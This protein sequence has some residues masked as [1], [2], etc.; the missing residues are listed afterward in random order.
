VGFFHADAKV[1]AKAKPK[2]RLQDI[3]VESLQRLGCGACPRDADRSLSS[4]KMRSQGEDGAEVFL[5]LAAPTRQDDA[6]GRFLEDAVGREI[7][8]AFGRRYAES[9]L[10]VGGAVQCAG[11]ETPG[12]A[13]IEC[14][15]GRVVADIE[16]ARPLVVVTVGDPPLAWATGLGGAIPHRGTLMVARI[17]RHECYVFPILFP[18]YVL[19]KKQFGGKSEY[20]MALHHDVARLKGLVPWMAQNPP[21]VARAPYDGGVEVVTGQEPGDMQRLE[22]ALGAIAAAPANAMDIETNCLRPFTHRRP[23]ILTAACGTFER[24]VAFALDHPDGWGSDH[25]R[26]RA[27]GLFYDFL[28]ES[29]RTACH[30]LAFEM[31]WIAADGGAHA[32][33]RS[34]WDDTMASAYTLDERGGTKSLGVQTQIHFG[35]DLKAQSRVDAARLLDYPIREVLRYNGMDAKWTNAVR[36]AHAPLLDAVPGFREL[37]EDKVALAP[38]L[39][40]TTAKG[41]P[42]DQAF[43]DAAVRRL[44]GE[45]AEIEARLRRDEDV[46]AFSRR[47]GTFSPTN[48]DHMVKLLK[49]LGREEI[50]VTDK[51]TGA[52]SVSTSEDILASIGDA[53]P[54]C[55]LVLEHR[56]V[57]KLLGTY[58]KPTADGTNVCP[59][60]MIRSAYNSMATVTDRLSADDPAVQNWPKRKHKWVRG[61]VSV[62]PVERATGARHWF[63]ALDYGQIE[64][65]VVGMASE[66]PNLVRACWTGYDVHKAWALR[67]VEIYPEVKD[68]IVSEFSVDWDEKGIKTLRQEM[69]NKWVFPQLFGSSM[70]SCA[71]AL[72]LPDWA[73]NDLGA[74]FW[75]EFRDVKKWHDRIMR[76]YEKNLYVEALTGTRRRG[77]MTKNEAINM[78]I[79][80]TAAAIVKRAMTALS[81]EAELRGDPE[82]QPSLNVHDD[83]STIMA[84]ATMEPKIETIA[85]IMCEHRYDFI[86]VPL[87]VEAS[88]GPNWADLEEVRVY[89]SDELF[90]L[91][92]PYA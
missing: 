60:G 4:P 77:P 14:C 52:V 26:R 50:E 72:H 56:S 36:D 30:N 55:G 7:E 61:M 63:V 44:A 24:T 18:N 57:S 47:Y 10:T 66:D 82:L 49:G 28:L 51:R 58:V 54:A 33:R 39:A 40:L 43:A 31:E 15:R 35:F 23:L 80:S 84:D 74:E 29:G 46:A 67:L 1:A 53:V 87:V 22:E 8:R 42:V 59:D 68:W 70:R 88:V 71:E 81:V 85:R 12:A 86:N 38:T 90:G 21:R 5:L 9:S 79:Q 73:A 27:R 3:P 64:F 20:E 48:P 91:R 13:E 45:A 17:G 25:Q 34:E 75:D 32:L 76:G 78:P 83:L 69:K 16:A 92:N 62:A 19:K 65:R 6:A 41:L 11:D 37:Y 89:R 2:A